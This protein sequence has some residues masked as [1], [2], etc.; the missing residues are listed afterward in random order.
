MSPALHDH[1]AS[2]TAPPDAS[3]LKTPPGQESLWTGELDME[4]V[5]SRV[6]AGEDPARQQDAPDARPSS[7]DGAEPRYGMNGETAARLW[8][9]AETAEEACHAAQDSEACLTYAE[10]LV[11][12]V[13]QT[14]RS[15]PPPL[16]FLGGNVNRV[17]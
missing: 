4:D 5:I 14:T 7:K 12:R 2:R 9:V 17:I 13:V 10:A 11:R 3:V 6:L 1:S 16:D 8:G 15:W